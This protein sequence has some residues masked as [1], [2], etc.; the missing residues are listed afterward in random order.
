LDVDQA[1]MEEGTVR[2]KDEKGKGVGA[3][4]YK[5]VM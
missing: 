4:G 2:I 1:A 5:K 3:Q